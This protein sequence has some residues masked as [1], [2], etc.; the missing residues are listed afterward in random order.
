M[1]Q[2]RIEIERVKAGAIGNEFSMERLERLEQKVQEEFY[3]KDP[4]IQA[5]MGEGS[6]E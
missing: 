3:S 4:S 6:S 5:M 1:V 2:E